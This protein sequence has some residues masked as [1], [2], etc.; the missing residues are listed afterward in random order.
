[1]PELNESYWRFKPRPYFRCRDCGVNEPPMFVVHDDIWLS[2][3]PKQAVLCLTCFE[4]RL[5]RPVVPLD[6]K[7]CGVTETFKLGHEIYSRG[8]RS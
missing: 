2:V 4:N 6:L 7:P 1:M 3:A 5:G 8:N